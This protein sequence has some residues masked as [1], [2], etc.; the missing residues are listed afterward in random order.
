MV[1]AYQRLDA[2]D[3]ACEYL[4][5]WLIVQF[6]LLAFERL[7]Q[8]MLDRKLL[9]RGRA[10]RLFIEEEAA[11]TL[12]LRM[13]HRHVRILEQCVEILAVARIEHDADGS[14]N[15]NL[16]RAQNHRLR[17]YRQQASCRP[18]RILFCRHA[19]E[20]HDELVAAMAAHVW[21][22]GLRMRPD[23]GRA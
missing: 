8:I 10:H 15:E 2:D 22:H 12:S 20:E 6:E 14:R 17:E 19:I 3:F 1:P 9:R 4:Y 23:A 16:V 13:V 11:A 18:R 5:L 7:A 21:F